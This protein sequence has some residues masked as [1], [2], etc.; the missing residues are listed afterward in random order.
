MGNP[1]EIRDV[2]DTAIWVAQYRARESA[3]PD[4]MFRDPLAKVL[5]GERGARIAQSF[6]KRSRYTEWTV[7]TRTVIID[8]FILAAIK[9]GVDAVLNLGAGLDTRPYRM[10]L[11]ASFQWVEADFP[12]MVEYKQRLLQGEKPR[13][14]LQSVGVDLSNPV[15]RREL[16]ASVAPGA[17][18]ILVITEGVV[19]YLTEEQVADLAKD[20]AEQPRFAFWL[21]EHF[22]PQV[23]PYL[24][25]TGS[26]QLM[27]N[28]PFQ[29]F[30]ADWQG[31]FLRNGW[32][33]RQ[34]SYSSEV[35]ARFRRRP[36][37]PWWARFVLPLMPKEVLQ[38]MKKMTGFMLMTPSR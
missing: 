17:K 24:K 1:G 5:A 22:A 9:D 29:F 37:M 36:P 27:A 34:I 7:I 3:R 33:C 30:P 4:A 2:S 31:H 20:L 15:A 38:R 28:A 19:P 25:A 26:S 8:D 11:P 12:H 32:S 13:C 10:E 21:A 6:G 14:Q 35:A 18:K 16:L 23:Y